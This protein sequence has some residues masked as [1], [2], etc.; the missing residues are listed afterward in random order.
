LAPEV[1]WEASVPLAAAPRT[2]MASGL[3]YY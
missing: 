2:T 1:M 3:V